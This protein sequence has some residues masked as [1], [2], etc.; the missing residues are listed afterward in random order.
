MGKSINVETFVCENKTI[1]NLTQY[2]KQ[3][4][5][6]QIVLIFNRVSRYFSPHST[7]FIIEVVVGKV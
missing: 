7:Q 4:S 2:I 5:S 1:S 6:P 3:N